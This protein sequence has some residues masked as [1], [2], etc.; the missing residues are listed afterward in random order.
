MA[1]SITSSCRPRPWTPA[2]CSPKCQ[3][4]ETGEGGAAVTDSQHPILNEASQC[5]KYNYSLL[6]YPVHFLPECINTLMW[7]LSV[8]KEAEAKLSGT[9]I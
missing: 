8:L 6:T 1:G 5:R 2:L 9:I 4:S 7:K 3:R